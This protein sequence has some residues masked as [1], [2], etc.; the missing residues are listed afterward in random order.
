V[1]EE[2]EGGELAEEAALAFVTTEPRT[3]AGVRALLAYFADVE[4][5]DRG[6]AWPDSFED[7]RDPAVI[8]HGGASTGYFVARAACRALARLS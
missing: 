5:I 3:V 1:R 6:M 7:E 4:V 8:R 2:K